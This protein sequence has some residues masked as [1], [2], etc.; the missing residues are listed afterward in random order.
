MSRPHRRRCDS[1]PNSLLDTLWNSSS[2][3]E[4]QLQNAVHNVRSALQQLQS[5][6]LASYDAIQSQNARLMESVA[7]AAALIESQQATCARL[8]AQRDDLRATSSNTQDTLSE[9]QKKTTSLKASMRVMKETLSRERASHLATRQKLFFVSSER[10]NLLRESEHAAA[11]MDQLR[12]Q[13]ATTEQKLEHEQA[14]SSSNLRKLRE[15]LRR[16]RKASQQQSPP[17][18]YETRQAKRDREMNA[19]E[20]E[21]S[22]DG[23]VDP[24]RDD[25]ARQAALRESIEKLRRIQE[26]ENRDRLKR[27]RAQDDEEE[28][29]RQERAKRQRLAEE[30]EREMLRRQA[31]E[32]QRRQAEEAQRRRQE[33]ADEEQKRNAWREATKQEEIRCQKR[34]MHNWTWPRLTSAAPPSQ[35]PAW[36]ASSS[37]SRSSRAPHF[38]RHSRHDVECPLARSAHAT[39]YHAR[40]LGRDQDSRLL[41][42]REDRPLPGRLQE[43]AV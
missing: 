6:D 32:E 42:V 3:D 1:S 35:P 38:R 28:R 13:L 22:T 16:E 27:K 37:C 33:Q 29:Q 21:A 15:A 9:V 40:R 43:A 23:D 31:E 4:N 30:Q 18:R 11:E 41:R 5:I 20:G 19:D 24:D 10:D 26:Q 12:Q 34:D 14:L 36:R 39:P 2:P 25:E 8:R 7:R 17:R